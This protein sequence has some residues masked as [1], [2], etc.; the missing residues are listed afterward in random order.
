[1]RDPILV[2]DQAQHFLG[3][4]F[5]ERRAVHKSRFG[6]TSFSHPISFR[7]SAAQLKLYGAALGGRAF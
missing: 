7:R 3:A 4:Q 1:M 2:V 6:R 5:I